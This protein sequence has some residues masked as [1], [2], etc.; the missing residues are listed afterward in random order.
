MSQNQRR[1]PDEIEADIRETRSELDET[2]HELEDRFSRERMKQAAYD[3]V[4]GGGTNEFFANL[5]KTVKENP[6][7]FL[8]TGVG[9]GWLM[10]AQRK[11]QR[12]HEQTYGLVSRSHR[13]ESVTL[14]TVPGEVPANTVVDAPRGTEA[15]H[16][17]TSISAPPDRPRPAVGEATHLGTH[18]ERSDITESTRP[19]A[20]GEPV[21]LGTP[22][23]RHETKAGGSP[24][25]PVV[26]E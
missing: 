15:V 19:G 25:E 12:R 3:R 14:P 2:L 18:Q 13:P 7:P 1:S 5:G 4:R 24:N 16:T 11:A 17:G 21:H 6:I 8:V 26:G 20:V 9:L 23:H 10:M 22:E